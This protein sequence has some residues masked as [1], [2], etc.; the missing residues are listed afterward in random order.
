MMSKF[1]SEEQAGEA[2]EDLPRLVDEA[3]KPVPN[4]KW[5]SVSIDGL[6]EVAKNVEKVGEP[7]VNLSKKILFLLTLGV[8]SS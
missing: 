5:Y 7:V 1:L 6:I 2:A 3:I 4:R 8:T